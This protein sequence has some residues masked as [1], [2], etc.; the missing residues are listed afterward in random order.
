MIDPTDLIYGLGPE[1]LL[2]IG[3]MV[4]L[5]FAAWRPETAAHSRNVA[6]ASMVLTLAVLAMVLFYAFGGAA[7]GPGLLASD[8]FR[9]AADIIILIATLATLALS[10]DYNRRE[11]I[12]SPEA[13]VLVLFAT[14][15]M[16]LLAAARDLMIVFLGI[17]LM[18]IAVY[19]LAGMNRR[20]QRSAE[21]S[22][23]YFLMGAFATAFLLY[24]IALI[25]G[26]TGSVN[27]E[28]LGA[29]IVQAGLP[30]DPMLAIG[31]ALLLIGFGF[32]VAAA[33]FHMWAPDVYEGSPT[34]IAAYMA[35]TVKTAAFVAL[36]RIFR[37][38]F[39]P[40]GDVWYMPVWWIATITMFVGNVTALRQKN[41]KRMLA[42]SSIAHGGY[43]MVALAASN[44]LGTSALLF[45]LFA[46][47]LATLGAFAV[48]I[49]LGFAGE[50]NLDITDY[51][52]LFDVR[53]GLAIAMAVFM[54]A[55]LGLPIVGG[56]GFIGKLAIIQSVLAE[57]FENGWTLAVVLVL[58]TII[59]A[60]Y[61]LYVVRVMF[62]GS[63][64]PAA[65]EY[66]PTPMLVR[67]VIG[68][69]A[70]VIIVLGLFPGHILNWA[71][72]GALEPP[73]FM[74]QLSTQS[75]GNGDGGGGRAAR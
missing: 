7:T 8:S 10:I 16:M 36:L 50:P 1:I 47:T 60:G 42:Y 71:R 13:H 2:T 15:G 5:I 33:P 23:K 9:W 21:A 48:V 18:S 11:G 38:S 61:Y 51:S 67:V 37:E 49:A 68:V 72:D 3:A 63:R 45:Y 59:S 14:S 27:L 53:P 12:L 66:P 62:M 22:L 20:S 43:I 34:P 25:Y 65:R 64:A 46:Y 26:A 54:F 74:T 58:T 19:V 29:R 4:L 57:P 39:V 32:K 40:L 24:G 41:I 6:I 75:V 70:A 44:T 28:V 31:I 35:A 56:I 55:L 52:G 73:R 69:S 17:E 30:A